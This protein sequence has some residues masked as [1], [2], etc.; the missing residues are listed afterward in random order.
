LV[1]KRSA[2]GGET[3]SE[4]AVLCNGA[5]AN[6]T[7]GLRTTNNPVMIVDGDIIHLIYS[8]W[9]GLEKG[10]NS[11]NLDGGVFYIKS[12]DDGLTWSEPR[13]ISSVCHRDEFPRNLYAAGPGHGIVLSDKSKNPGMLLTPVWMSSVKT[14]D[15]MD[16]Q[17]PV[18]TTLYS[19]DRGET[20]QTGEVILSTEEIINPNETVAVELSD[21][22]VMFN[23]RNES[24]RNRRSVS[25]SPTGYDNWATPWFDENLPDPICFG[26]IIRYDKDT[27]LFVNCANTKEVAGF[28]MDSRINL[29][30]RASRDDGK[31]WEASR[32]L[33]PG[34]SGYADIA[35]GTDG[36]IYVLYDVDHGETSM[37]LLRFDIDW[38]YGAN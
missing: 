1:M 10:K 24:P 36:M 8:V 20:W 19:L 7:G 27:I 22:S 17:L 37:N 13:D 9:Y 33:V 12:V 18:A 35:V 31:T 5:N 25:V 2:D 15:D 11:R 21:G 30:V 4:T 28:T 6:L 23:M 38:V 14:A 16:H 34:K 29:T 3:W 32:V 26:S